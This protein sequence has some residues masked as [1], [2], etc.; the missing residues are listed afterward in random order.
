M[1]PQI[2]QLVHTIVE[3][4]KLDNIAVFHADDGF[5]TAAANYCVDQ[6]TKHGSKNPLVTHYNRYTLDLSKPLTLLC[7]SDPRVIICISTSMPA[8]KIINMLFRKGFYGCTF[9]GIDSSF[10]VPTILKTKGVPFSYSSSVPNPINSSIP[11]AV[12]YRRDLA[13]L[14]PDEPVN[15]LSFAYYICARLIID[16]INRQQNTDKQAI[17]KALENMK[18]IDFDGFPISFNEQNRYLFGQRTW[19]LE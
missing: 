17:M 19:L 6:L 3:E 8:V 13:A 16:A 1:E 9:F 18:N 4:K 15:I 2:D 11:L 5:S 12:Q 10:L 14:F 7:S